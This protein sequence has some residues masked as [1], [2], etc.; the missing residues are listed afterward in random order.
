MSTERKKRQE[1]GREMIEI[2]GQTVSWWDYLIL[3]LR[4][5]FV[6]PCSVR[7]EGG[8]VEV[9]PGEVSLVGGSSRAPGDQALSPSTHLWFV[10][11]VKLNCTELMKFSWKCSHYHIVY[12]FWFTPTNP[13]LVVTLFYVTSL[14]CEFIH[15]LPHSNWIRRVIFISLKK[16]IIILILIAWYSGCS[17]C[18]VSTVCPHCTIGR[19]SALY[20]IW[21]PNP[22]GQ[23]QQINNGLMDLVL[24]INLRGIG[25]HWRTVSL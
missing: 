17:N 18:Q 24:P 6:G 8:F 14:Y 20:D 4:G 11:T 15:N 10:N 7:H 16:I 21:S 5:V 23:P 9:N 3:C 2:G 19:F 22:A 1:E 25:K 13:D 12:R